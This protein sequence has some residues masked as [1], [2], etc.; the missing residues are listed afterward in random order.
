MQ[1]LNSMNKMNTLLAALIALLLFSAGCDK[2]FEQVNS[3]PNEPEQVN[4]SLLMPTVI[5]GPVNTS[6]AYSMSTGNVVMQNTAM[7]LFGS[8]DRYNWTPDDFNGYWTGLYSDLRNVQ[9]LYDISAE[10]GQTN[11]QAVALIMRSWIF[12]MLTDAYGDI[13]YTQAIKAKSDGEYSPVYD[14]QQKVYEGILADLR[15]A[16]ELIDPAGP[17]IQGDI[18]YNGDLARWQKFANSLRLRLLMRVSDKM[19]VSAEMQ[20]IVDNP[21]QYPVFESNDDNAALQYLESYPNQW[22]IHTYRVGTF[23]EYRMSKTMVDTLTKF[24]DPRLAVFAEPTDNSVAAGNPEYVGVPN[25]LLDDEAANYNG[26]PSDQS[27]LGTRYYEEPNAAKGLIMTYSEVL[28]I[29]AEAAEKGMITGDA[30]T[31]YEDGI[32]ASFDKYGVQ[33]DPGYLTQPDVAWDSNRAFEQIGTQKWISLYFTGLE[34]WFDW[35]RT[36]YPQLEPSVRNQ[37][38]DRIPVR[39]Q[40]PPQEQSLNAENY[41]AAVAA[42]GPDNINTPMWLIR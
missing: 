34:S 14:S 38:G 7:V 28:F 23:Q 11:Y 5:R 36:G 10:S 9:N 13:P 20:Q 39:F 18:L 15:K 35:R 4:P 31:F 6:V 42:Q 32:R 40:Y 2:G 1:Y 19:D 24:N 27:R 16:N 25:G 3:N 26:S 12:S 21:G 37:N 33:M 30:Q 41:K 17:G 8:I 22:P 29:K